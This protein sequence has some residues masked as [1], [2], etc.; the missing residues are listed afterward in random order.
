MQNINETLLPISQ[1]I[2][3]K[4]WVMLSATISQYKND[5]IEF[6]KLPKDVMNH[7]E[8]WGIR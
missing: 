8:K 3:K 6:K 7:I 1:I 4:T 2:V 5:S